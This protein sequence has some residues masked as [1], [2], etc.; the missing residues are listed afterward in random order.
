MIKTISMTHQL[1]AS[2]LNVLAGNSCD[3]GTL[4]DAETWLIN[5][6]C[7][8]SGQRKWDGGEPIKDTLD[9]FNNGNGDCSL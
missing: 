8:G 6:G 9:D 1:I 3:A 4:S 5:H 7:A 2:E